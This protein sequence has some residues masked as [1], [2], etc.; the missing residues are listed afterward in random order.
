MVRRKNRA[1]ST[2][3][4]CWLH[5][6]TLW[7][8]QEENPS[9]SRSAGSQKIRLSVFL[10]FCLVEGC[11]DEKTGYHL[12]RHLL[13]TST[14]ISWRKVMTVCFPIFTDFPQECS[15]ENLLYFAV[16]RVR[17]LAIASRESYSSS[18]NI[19][20]GRLNAH[21][22]HSCSDWRTEID[23]ETIGRLRE[24]RAIE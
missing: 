20:I 14:L 4:S 15:R 24:S 16:K 5:L 21:S 9:N 2:R 22:Q 10:G 12:V 7:N 13:G 11:F 23:F 8:L 17:L 19:Q 1:F 6:L 3:I 18:W